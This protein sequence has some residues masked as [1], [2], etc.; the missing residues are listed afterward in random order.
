VTVEQQLRARFPRSTLNPHAFA[1][2][3]DVDVAVVGEFARIR[4]VRVRSTRRN[5]RGSR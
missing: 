3:V 5:C 1:V 2:D 4:P